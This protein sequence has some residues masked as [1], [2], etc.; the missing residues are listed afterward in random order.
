LAVED[1]E[2]RFGRKPAGAW[3]S[4]GS[5]SDEAA[6]VLAGAGF[7]W[8]ASDEEILFR[9]LGHGGGGAGGRG[10]LYRPYRLE[11]ASGPVSIVFRDK[12][13]SDLVGFTY[14]RWSPR[15][16]AEDFIGRVMAAGRSGSGEGP[17][18]VTVILDGENCWEYYEKDGG[19]FL[20]E[21]YG[22]LS[23]EPDLVMT[24]PGRYLSD[25]APSATLRGLFPGSWIDHSFHMWIGEP[26]KNQAWDHLA[27]ARDAYSEAEAEGRGDLAGARRLLDVAEGSDWFWWYVASPH[28][29]PQ[30][31]F[32]RIFR[33]YLRETYRA[34][35]KTPPRELLEPIAGGVSPFRP[36]ES[37]PVGLIKP[38][39]DGAVTTFYEW[40][41]GGHV[42]AD[43]GGAAMARASLYVMDFYYGFDLSTFFCRVDLTEK[44]RQE[45]AE[46][47]VVLEFAAPNPL[48]L[49]VPL[50]RVAEPGKARLVRSGHAPEERGRACMG[51]VLELA[52]S[53]DDLAFSGGQEVWLVCH[54][55][56]EGK[57][58]ESFPPH[59]HVSFRAP[60]ADFEKTMWSV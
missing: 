4:E 22:R 55:M 9:S 33:E 29:P 14:M 6:A 57:V 26:A 25:Y 18:L 27:A 38:V 58:L 31:A 49:E 3:P 20:D 50:S 36:P 16:A 10:Q 21:L 44:G 47:S 53:F 51:R 8:I 28:G 5:L 35:G 46:L 1:H 45:A 34:L 11:T 32:D 41:H 12:Q 7:R 52:A 17:P 40:A 37:V 48:R 30:P 59:G 56:R 19:P 60:D 42:S 54:V 43:A 13:L 15:A 39:I 24:T 2:R 23:R